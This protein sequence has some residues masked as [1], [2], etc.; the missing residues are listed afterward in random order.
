MRRLEASSSI[1]MPHMAVPDTAHRRRQRRRRQ[2]WAAPTASLKQVVTS[3]RWLSLVLFAVCVYALYL[4]GNVE[5]FYLTYI[6]VE[7][8]SSLTPAEVVEASGLAGQHVF[9]AD[10]ARAANSIGDIPGVVSATVKLSWPNEIAIRIVEDTPIM[11]WEQNG[12]PYWVTQ[13]GSVV[14]AR[15]ELAGLLTVRTEAALLPDTDQKGEGGA[16]GAANGEMEEE[17]AV[18][19]RVA[20]E[21]VEGALQLRQLRPEISELSYKSLEGLSFRDG[22]WD[23]FFGTGTDMRQKLAVY[24]AVVAQLEAEGVTPAYV[25]VANQEKPYYRAFGR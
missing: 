6:P 17:E 9:S 11:I 12:V 19:P 22:E 21:I 3:A 16:A 15:Q 1:P 7:G 10:P 20:P 24:E 2:R 8:T 14:P 25:S 18:M 23:A 5:D 4:V 13:S